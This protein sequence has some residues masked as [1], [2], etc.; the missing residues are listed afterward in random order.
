MSD[1]SAL[2]YTSSCQERLPK[3]NQDLS[4]TVA[5]VRAATPFISLEWGGELESPSTPIKPPP[6]VEVVLRGQ[7]SSAMPVAEFVVG[8]R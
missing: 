3:G 4:T 7:S 5:G 8:Y 6:E 2:T 1:Q